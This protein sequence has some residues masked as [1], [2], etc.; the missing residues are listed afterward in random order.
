LRLVVVGGW[1]GVLER[2]LREAERD[3]A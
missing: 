1:P 2:F 3:A